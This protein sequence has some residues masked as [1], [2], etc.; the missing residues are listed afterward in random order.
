MV[1]S[2]SYSNNHDIYMM[3]YYWQ[4]LEDTNFTIIMMLQ[5][6]EELY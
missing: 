4:E 3:K 1:F 6:D 5:I 2:I